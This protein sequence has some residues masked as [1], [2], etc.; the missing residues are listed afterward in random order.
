M[1]GAGVFLRKGARVS[2]TPAFIRPTVIVLPDIVVGGGGQRRL[3]LDWMKQKEQVER[4]N[5]G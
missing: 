4:R 2:Q 3:P 5:A 1:M